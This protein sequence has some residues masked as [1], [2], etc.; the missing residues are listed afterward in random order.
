MELVKINPTEFGLTEDTAKNIQAQFAPMLAK[1][2]ELEAE[3]NEVV[4]LPIDS[5]EAA[6]KAKEVRLKYVKV[7][8]G[9]AEI[10]KVQKAFY[11]NGGRFVDGWKNAQLFASQGKEQRLQE[12]E[13]YQANLERQRIEALQNER[14]EKIRPYVEDTTALNLGTMQEDVWEAYFD[15]KKRAYNDRIEA[16]KEAERLRIE[17]EKAERERIEAQRV[18]NERLKKEAEARE[19][20]FEAERKEAARKQAEIEAQ[21]RKEREEAEAKA[22]AIAEAAR[23]ER[24]ALEAQ[25]A[26]QKKAEQEAEA[27]R[28]AAEAK[29][30]SE[31]AKLAKAP[32]KK[33]L[34]VWVS[35]FEIPSC[36][37]EHECVSEIQAKFEAFKKWAASQVEQ[38]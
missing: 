2:V 23:K 34:N 24:E 7:R 3:F 37:I 11:L 14:V 12:I 15:A 20:A 10:H 28:L 31:A 1:M 30:A 9:T 6:K 13:D 35:G 5:P 36:S 32:V 17:A 29:A 33:Q 27:A 19:S 21:A 4:Q 26:A 16:E 18:E 22:R 38:I 8:T 25:I